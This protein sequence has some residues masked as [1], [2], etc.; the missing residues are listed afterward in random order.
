[1]EEMNT[2]YTLSHWKT[3]YKISGITTIMMMLF[4]LFDTIAW[5]LLGPYPNSGHA[6]FT[7][8]EEKNLVGII[9]L[10]FPTYFGMMLYYLTFL[11][12]YNLLKKINTVV[13]TFATLMAFVGLTI[14]LVT[15]SGFTVLSLSNQYFETTQ[16]VQQAS[17][18][19]SAETSMALFSSGMMKGGFFAEGALVIFSMIMLK[20]D[21]FGKWIA[22][23]GILGHGLDFLR[24]CM[25]L[26]FIP[27]EVGAV[28]LVVG[29]LPQLL[30][31]S[32]VGIKIFQMGRRQDF[33]YSK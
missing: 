11:S 23:L 8:L 17:Q 1:M 31:V 20:S 6:W 5:M 18:I 14:I 13:V 21:Y 28:L 22:Y 26:A 27:E 3:F 32:L 25:N 30:W 33:S 2:D 9:L 15:Y 12:L 29:G 10:A 19:I 7:L 16:V 4:F 24:I